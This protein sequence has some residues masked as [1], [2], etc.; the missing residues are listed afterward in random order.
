MFHSDFAIDVIGQYNLKHGCSYSAKDF[1]DMII[2]IAWPENKLPFLT[3]TNSAIFQ[4]FVLKK[5]KYDFMINDLQKKI[6]IGDVDMA[7][8][9]GFPAKDIIS[10]TSHLVDDIIVGRYTPEDGYASWIGSMLAVKMG[11]N[12]V[13]FND[14]EIALDIIEGWSWYRKF[15]N[16]TPDI[17]G[18]EIE[19]W[20]SIW[21]S[22]D[23]NIPFSF[24]NIKDSDIKLPKFNGPKRQLSKLPWVG[25]YYSLMKNYSKDVVVG[26]VYENGKTT[27][28]YGFVNFFTSPVK[29]LFETYQKLFG[30]SEFIN[31]KTLLE[32]TYGSTFGFDRA[33]ECGSIGLFQLKPYSERD[34]QNLING[35]KQSTEIE[36]H[37]IISWIITYKNNMDINQNAEDLSQMFEDYSSKEINARTIRSNAIKGA[38]A[39]KSIT[40]HID[41]L[42]S[43]LNDDNRVFDNEKIN[44]MVITLVNNY[45]SP[46]DIALLNT[47]IKFKTNNLKQILET[48]KK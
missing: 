24:S 21:I 3:P 23:R 42:T 29:R 4:H 16:T 10:T 18:N 25:T 6:D 39:S 26:F 36:I 17:K 30:E 9:P 40:A 31:N 38:L 45:R 48:S 33:V 47:L 46:K 44:N 15:L 19:V 14:I 22:R 43:Y 34:V 28:T 35:K 13:I 7:S 12:N 37:A 5:T 41:V 20:N 11:K 27:N 32:K 8:M 1:F 2:P